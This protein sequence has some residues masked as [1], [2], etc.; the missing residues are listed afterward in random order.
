MDEILFKIAIVFNT[1][2][3]KVGQNYSMTESSR[4]RGL[5]ET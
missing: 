1:I 3:L 5:L 4:T 2:F